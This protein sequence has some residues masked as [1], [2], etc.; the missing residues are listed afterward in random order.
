MSTQEQIDLLLQLKRELWDEP[1]NEMISHIIIQPELLQKGL[2]WSDQLLNETIHLT[3]EFYGKARIWGAGRT[4]Y[5]FKI[6]H[7]S[8]FGGG[9]KVWSKE[10]NDTKGNDKIAEL[11]QSDVS[12]EINNYPELEPLVY[13]ETN[14]HTFVFDLSLTNQAAQ[15]Y[16]EM[17]KTKLMDE[18]ENNNFNVLNYQETFSR[19][20]DGFMT[21]DILVKRR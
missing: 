15:P 6:D 4:Y 14:A 10:D 11:L 2:E 9:L 3:Y 18:L 7:N 13:G 19:S 20:T 5:T 17:I 8:R 1:F 12:E 16:H 21:I